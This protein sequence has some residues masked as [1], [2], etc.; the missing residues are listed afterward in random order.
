MFK[1]WYKTVQR[2]CILITPG[3]N[4]NSKCFYPEISKVRVNSEIVTR[5]L[6]GNVLLFIRMKIGNKVAF[7]QLIFNRYYSDSSA[8]DKTSLFALRNL[9]NWRDVVSDAQ[10]NPT[11][12]K[13]FVNLVLDVNIIAAALTFFRMETT[14]DQPTKHSF[15][16]ELAV[17]LRV[18][19]HRYF[20]RVVKEF[21]ET[22]IVDETFYEN[23]FGNIQALQ[24][25]ERART[26]EPVLPSGKDLCRFPGCESSFKHDGFH[27]MRHELSHDPPP[28]I[29]EEP[30]L[31]TTVPDPTDQNPKPKDDV[32]DY[33]CGL[34]NMSLVLKNF[35]DAIK[36]GD[37]E[38]IV[39]CIQL[40]ALLAPE[41]L[42]E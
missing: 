31:V 17:G 7:I 3:S 25:W 1:N 20:H 11:P 37:G 12:C 33:H 8:T 21:I 13:R 6:C 19:R 30:V 15:N 41:K 28:T 24:E 29:P 36:E 22:Y 18:V 34:M 26:Y 2:I 38:R 10:H 14:D 35:M 27:R 23:H 16:P 5:T 40:F 9:V 4:S 32:F 39:K 42:K